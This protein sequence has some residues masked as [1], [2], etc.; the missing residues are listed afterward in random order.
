MSQ[1]DQDIKIEGQDKQSIA[2]K[3][4]DEAKN[5]LAKRKSRTLLYN[6]IEHLE[7][8]T[9]QQYHNKNLSIDGAVYIA[10]MTNNLTESLSKE[11]L[12]C[13]VAKEVINK[14][15][16]E[17][18]QYKNKYILSVASAVVIGVVL[19]IIVAGFVGFKID[20]D[21]GALYGIIAGA[22]GGGIISSGLRSAYSMWA[23]NRDPLNKV[24]DPLKKV[25]ETALKT[26]E[27]YP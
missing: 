10:D 11:G 22:F 16:D 19:G 20:G 7:N 26:F 24:R 21:S 9:L 27:N 8:F 23:S 4:F 2:A 5:R 1:N 25:A 3:K 14:F 12:T 17:T 13:D 6:E 15:I 18:A